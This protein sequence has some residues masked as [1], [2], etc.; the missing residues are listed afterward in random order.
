MFSNHFETGLFQ[1]PVRYLVSDLGWIK[2]EVKRGKADYGR[3]IWVR[4]GYTVQNGKIS[5]PDG[6]VEKLSEHLD[7]LSF[8]GKQV[9]LI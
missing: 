8:K 9:D 3:Q 5:G 4:P 2:R 6:Y 7:Q 1:W